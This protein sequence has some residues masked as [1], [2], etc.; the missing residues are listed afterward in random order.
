PENVPIWF[1]GTEIA[2]ALRGCKSVLVE[3]QEGDRM[4][5]LITDGD[6]I[7]LHGGNAE[8]IARELKEQN[9]TVFAIIIAISQIQDEIITITHTTGGEAFEGA[10]PRR[11]GPSSA[12]STR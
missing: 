10:T 6:S 1:N 3:R 5:V 9:I 8:A 11:C 4:I 12:A 7:D 2:R